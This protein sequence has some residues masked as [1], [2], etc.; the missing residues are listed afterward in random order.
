MLYLLNSR[1][2]ISMKQT[3]IILCG[4]PFSGKTTFAT[5]LA[6]DLDYQRIDLDEIK[7]EL[8][9][10]LIKDE[11]ILQS[12]WDIIYQKMYQMILEI[13]NSGRGIIHD[14]GNFTIY[15]RGIINQIAKNLNI[16]FVTIFINT[17][18]LIAKNRMIKNRQSKERFDISDEAFESTIKEMEIPQKNENPLT[19]DNKA[20]YEEILIRLKSM[21]FPL[22]I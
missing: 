7:F 12:D 14:T 5:R 15:E 18:I 19:F 13:L 2:T 8:L 21:I 3:L 20:S 22:N 16:P 17:P 1:Y 11:D 6:R 4:I 9:G 10:S